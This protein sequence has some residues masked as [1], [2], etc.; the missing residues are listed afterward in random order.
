MTDVTVV[1]RHLARLGGAALDAEQIA[2]TAAQNTAA[3]SEFVTAGCALA[4]ANVQEALL[5]DAA[6]VL[7]SVYDGTTSHDLV[8]AAQRLQVVSLTLAHVREHREATRVRFH[9]ACKALR[10]D[11]ALISGSLEAGTPHKAH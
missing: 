10:H 3:L 8:T 1:L 11:G 4:A 2:V 7:L 5:I 6:E 9:E